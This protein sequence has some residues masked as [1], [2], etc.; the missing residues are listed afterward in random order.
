MYCGWLL[1]DFRLQAT[2]DA[3][4]AQASSPSKDTCSN[5]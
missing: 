5:A 3:D 4:Q 2:S 1:L